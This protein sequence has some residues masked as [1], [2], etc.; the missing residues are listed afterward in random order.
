MPNDERRKEWLAEVTA[1]LERVL[2]IEVLYLK[3]L[4]EFLRKYMV[5]EMSQSFES[6][7]DEFMTADKIILSKQSLQRKERQH[8]RTSHILRR[9]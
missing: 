1:E 7:S 8:I 6:A 3:I 2:K 5:L 4:R 9:P